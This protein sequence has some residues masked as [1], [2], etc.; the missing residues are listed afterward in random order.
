[1]TWQSW[2]LYV[3][4]RPVSSVAFRSIVLLQ[5]VMCVGLMEPSPPLLIPGI[6]KAP[7]ADIL[8][9]TLAHCPVTAYVMYTWDDRD[10][11]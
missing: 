9:L 4:L 8:R 5:C 7:A 1:M 6:N 3:L 10:N 11:T 2:L